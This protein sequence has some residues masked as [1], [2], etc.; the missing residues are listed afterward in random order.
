MAASKHSFASHRITRPDPL[1][2]DKARF[3]VDGALRSGRLQ[4]PTHCPVCGAKGIQRERLKLLEAHHFD[5]S[6]PFDVA[7]LCH[8]CHIDLHQIQHLRGITYTSLESFIEHRT[9]HP[10]ILGHYRHFPNDS[11]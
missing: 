7:W 3:M 2:R 10:D 6:R 1:V 8:T 9:E 11:K 4:K 5:Y